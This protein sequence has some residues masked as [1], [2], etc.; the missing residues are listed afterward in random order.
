MTRTYVVNATWDD[1]A[2]VWVAVSD[3]VPGLVAEASSIPELTKK[4]AILI[5]ELLESNG[6]L[7]EPRG[8]D[9]PIEVVAHQRF[10]VSTS[11]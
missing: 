4:L 11:I 9:I 6:A 1:E 10:S 5:P 8:H 3:D 2:S 7:P